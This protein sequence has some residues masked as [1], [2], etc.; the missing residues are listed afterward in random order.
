MML[1]VKGRH[2]SKV[3]LAKS[4]LHVAPA[5]PLHRAGKPHV[6]KIVFCFFGGFFVEAYKQIAIARYN[7][8]ELS[9][10]HYT[11]QGV[12][13]HPH[14]AFEETEVTGHGFLEFFFFFFF[15]F[16]P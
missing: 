3:C 7:R 12:E 14:T 8:S 6:A 9:A 2:T 11:W 10:V 13:A 5:K 15:F 1:R 4:E 16:F